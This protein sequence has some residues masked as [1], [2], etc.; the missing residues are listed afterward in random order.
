MLIYGTK[1]A[2]VGLDECLV[3]CPSCETNSWADVQVVAKYL[4]IYWLPL[5]PYS[6][7]A[8]VVCKKCGLARYGRSFDADL[9][10]NYREIKYK[11]RYPWQTYIGAAA[12]TL[13]LMW[14]VIR[15]ILE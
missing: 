6:K 10:G 3:K 4:H 15:G 11:F 7:E 1:E 8:H 13:L 2:H 9:V 5:F 14:I 12:V